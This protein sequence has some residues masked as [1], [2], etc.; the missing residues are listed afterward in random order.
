MFGANSSKGRKPQI[1]LHLSHCPAQP[2]ALIRIIRETTTIKKHQKTAILITFGQFW[3]GP[4]KGK[5]W[6]M[7]HETKNPGTQSFRDRL[8]MALLLCKPE[9]CGRFFVQ[10]FGWMSSYL[11]VCLCVNFVLTCLKH[12]KT[13]FNC[14]SKNPRVYLKKTSMNRAEQINVNAG[15]LSTTEAPLTQTCY[16]VLTQLGSNLNKWFCEVQVITLWIQPSAS[17]TMHLIPSVPKWLENNTISTYQRFQAM[18]DPGA[19]TYVLT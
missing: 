4:E 1:N 16:L 2:L 10:F 8:S 15:A 9:V 5:W 11:T 18:Q 17:K 7:L 6:K 13:C 12:F 14:L 19:L 3:L